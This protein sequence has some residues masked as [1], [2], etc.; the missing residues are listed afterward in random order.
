MLTAFWR[1]TPEP[2]LE[3]LLTLISHSNHGVMTPRTEPLCHLERP[4][5]GEQTELDL[6][7]DLAELQIAASVAGHRPSTRVVL[8][9]CDTPGWNLVRLIVDELPPDGRFT[10][11]ITTA[12]ER[13]V[14]RGL[15]IGVGT[16]VSWPPPRH[17]V[18]IDAL[19]ATYEVEPRPEGAFFLWVTSDETVPSRVDIGATTTTTDLALY[20]GSALEL[21]V[22]D[23][24]RG[25]PLPGLDLLVK[26]GVP[27][28][29]KW[30]D[31]PCHLQGEHTVAVRTDAQGRAVVATLPP[32]TPA[33]DAATRHG[34]AASIEVR[35]DRHPIATEP[36]WK[37]E[38]AVARPDPL[39]VTL[40][41][42][43]ERPR[44]R[45]TGIAPPICRG[46]RFDGDPPCTIAVARREA[47]GSAHR[48]GSALPIGSDGDFVFEAAP[49]TRWFLWAERDGQRM[50]EVAAVEVVAQDI[51]PS[52]LA[53]RRGTEVT[54]RVRGVASP[55]RIALWIEDRVAPIDADET[56]VEVV[57]DRFERRL[58]L[59]GPTTLAIDR[60]SPSG[61]RAGVQRL[62]IDPA[63]QSLVELQFAAPTA[64]RQVELVLRGATLPPP[65][66]SVTFMPVEPRPGPFDS[67][68]SVQL[69]R[70]GRGVDPVSLTPGRYLWS[71]HSMLHG[72]VAGL[73]DVDATEPGA[74]LRIECEVHSA[75]QDALASGFV[76]DGFGAVEVP[77]WG[78]SML[79]WRPGKGLD[80]GTPVYVPV[81]AF[82]VLR[83]RGG[84]V[85]VALV[86]ASLP[87]SAALTLAPLDGGAPFAF[88]LFRIELD[89]AGRG[90]LPVALTPGRWFW[91]LLGTID[92]IVAGVIEVVP[93]VR[94][95]P[96]ALQCT[97]ERR[98]G[99]EGRRGFKITQLDGC[100]LNLAMHC[101]W[102]PSEPTVDGEA[103]YLVPVGA[104]TTP[105]DPSERQFR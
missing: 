81:D 88:E 45:V 13:R 42:D 49:A 40:Q 84:P 92:G 14:P 30:G 96:L 83:E 75:E 1:R 8:S 68:A 43:L 51:G 36:L 59:D 17:G 63:T 90:E 26:V 94:D 11:A 82:L 99:P 34:G 18:R 70:A 5:V 95:E 91:R 37:A 10:G 58:L 76:I 3:E 33:R 31:T 98:T 86:G 79:A 60:L 7:H 52:E 74:P 32:S 39:Q 56:Y 89:A 9:D 15:T 2:D 62:T 80:D 104:V 4:I 66:A 47:E 23:I 20:R 78:R 64:L 97:V 67:P 103:P 102:F 46:A 100:E 71:L 77:D 57:G 12:G 54:L 29:T 35:L 6:P 105:I 101:F 41:L 27:V 28:V 72:V 21:T 24:A 38:L 93:G 85:S 69:D 48:E 73:V 50:S 25:E 22:V 19:V 44:R 55:D 87:T 65:D 61:A 53:P 16:N